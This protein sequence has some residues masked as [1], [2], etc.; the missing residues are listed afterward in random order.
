[1]PAIITRDSATGA[2]FACGLLLIAFAGGTYLLFDWAQSGILFSV[3]MAVCFVTCVISSLLGEKASRSDIATMAV[4]AAF[5][6]WL[7]ARNL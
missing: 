1:M 6:I 7:I 5:F 4:A 3:G 2:A